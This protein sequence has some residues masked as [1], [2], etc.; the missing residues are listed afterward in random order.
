MGFQQFDMCD[1]QSF[2]S[3][4]AYAQ[5]DQ[6]LCLSLV[7]SMTVELLTEHHLEFLSL[8]GGFTGSYETTLVKMPRCWKSHVTAQFCRLSSASSIHYHDIGLCSRR[9]VIMFGLCFMPLTFGVVENSVCS[10]TSFIWASSQENLS[11]GFPTKRDSNQPAQ[12]Q[13][14]ARKLKYR[15]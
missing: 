6:S 13:I 11:L 10:S 2:R 8:I 12:L 15:S 7:Y 9:S 1:Q 4:C 14:L 5:S 3:I